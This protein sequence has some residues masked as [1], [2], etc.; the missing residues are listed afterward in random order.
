[1]CLCLPWD[2]YKSL[3][4]YNIYLILNLVYIIYITIT[5]ILLVC[6]T[7]RNNLKL[8][9]KDNYLG[10]E[11]LLQKNTKPIDLSFK[12]NTNKCSIPINI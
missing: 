2:F 4:R 9:Q 10:Y 7:C 12:F 11:I 3:L 1:M 6:N 5:N 8:I